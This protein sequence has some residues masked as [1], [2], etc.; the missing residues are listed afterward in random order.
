[1][2]R[3]GAHLARRHASV[4]A[5]FIGLGRQKVKCHGE[6]QIS[7]QEK[8]PDEPRRPAKVRPEGC[9][10]RG[11]ENHHYR[12]RPKLQVHW[13]RADDVAKQDKHRRDKERDLGRA[14][15]GICPVTDYTGK[16]T[17]RS[18]FST[19]VLYSA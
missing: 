7:H 11:D 2:L 5:S 10:K 12:A 6:E 1:M 15:Q 9:G 19:S 14:A 18:R 17:E 8:Q 16:W 4:D 3:K 13:R